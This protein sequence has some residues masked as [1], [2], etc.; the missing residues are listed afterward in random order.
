MPEQKL[1]SVCVCTHDRPAYLRACL[2]GLRVQTAR[3]ERFEVLVV[4]SAS[5][6]AAAAEAARLTRTLPNGRYLRVDRPGVSLARNTGAHSAQAA[7]I[8]YVDDDAIPDPGWVRAILDVTARPDAPAVIGGRILPHWE[9][10]LPRWWPGRL[11][12]VL[13]ILEH[14]G[15]GE[16]RRPGLPRTV[17]PY[18]ANM[19]VH[20]PALLSAGGFREGV[21]RYG[22]ALLSD[23]EV[24]LAWRLQNSGAIARYEPSIVVH[25]QIQAARLTPSWL[26]RRQFWQGASAV[27]T[28]RLL[29]E[30]RAVWRALP[31]R[32]LVATL[33]AP[34]ALIPPSSPALMAFRWRRAYSAGFVRAALGWRADIAA[35]S[36]RTV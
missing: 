20:V 33:F 7:W 28:R 36:G 32:C 2:D 34:T 18:A 15:A 8:A 11:R 23:E 21:G 22:G 14:D 10:P 25:H 5:S 3:A 9:A 27:V 13:S 19:V 30:G 16:F 1:L 24:Q 26:L 35:R 31:R 29:G 6:T 4:D 17:E 12:G